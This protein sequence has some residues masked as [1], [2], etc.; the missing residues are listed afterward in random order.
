M[1]TQTREKL[2]SIFTSL[3]LLFQY[4]IGIFSYLPAPVYAGPNPPIGSAELEQMRNGDDDSP[5]NPPS[6][7]HGNAGDANSHLIEGYSQS[8]RAILEDL[9]VG[10]PITLT[11]GYDIKHSGAHAIDYLTQYNRLDDHS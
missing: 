9:P 8:Y 4:V 10:V 1:R 11:I 6:W 5:S 2:F 7:E 3:T